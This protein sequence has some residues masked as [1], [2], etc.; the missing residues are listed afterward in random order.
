MSPIRFGQIVVTV[1]ILATL[2]CTTPKGLPSG[3][4][5]VGGGLQIDYEAPTDGTVILVEKV[6]GRMVATESLS[7]GSDFTFGPSSGVWAELL[8][9]LFGT[10]SADGELTLQ[11][12]TN[13]VFQLYFVPTK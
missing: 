10:P 1:T 8:L 9:T 3:A 4:Q 5:L 2:G 6:T 7:S 11:M 13:A 12:P